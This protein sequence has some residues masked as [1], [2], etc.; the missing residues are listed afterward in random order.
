MTTSLFQR[1]V[2]NGRNGGVG[3]EQRRVRE[4]LATF[5]RAELVHF[6]EGGYALLGG[7]PNDRIQAR[8][9]ISLFG[10]DVVC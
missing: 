3:E 10:H 9:W 5:G 8:E 6:E 4:V 7:S 2:G 1:I